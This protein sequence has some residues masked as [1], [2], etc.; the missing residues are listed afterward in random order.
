METRNGS[1]S[2]NARTN[3]WIM[4]LPVCPR[5]QNNIDNKISS[6]PGACWCTHRRV[7]AGGNARIYIVGRAI[8]GSQ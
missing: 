3:V 6:W 5:P 2:W 7:V 4:Q 8:T 1:E